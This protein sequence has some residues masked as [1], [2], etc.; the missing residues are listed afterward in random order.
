MIYRQL[1]IHPKPVKLGPSFRIGDTNLLCTN[2]QIHAEAR[3]MFFHENVF[4][5]PEAVFTGDLGILDKL[6]GPLYRLPRSRLAILQRLDIS[7]PVGGNAT[8]WNVL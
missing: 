8:L 5:I 2:R 7:V 4:V 3:E 6:E 1:L